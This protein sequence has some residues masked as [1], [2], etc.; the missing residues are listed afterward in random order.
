MKVLFFITGLGYGGAETETV[1]LAYELKKRGHE[2]SFITIITPYANGY[3]TDLKNNGIPVHALHVN[4]KKNLAFALPRLMKWIKQERP[5]II[6]AQMYAPNIISR[7]LKKFSS[8]NYYLINTIQNTI[9]GGTLRK[10]AYRMTSGIP[11]FVSHVSRRGYNNY[12]GAN[13]IKKETSGFIP[14]SV[15]M[16][17]FADVK[18][19]DFHADLNLA[20]GTFVFLAVARLERQKDYPTLFKAVDSL[21]KMTDKPFVA[22][23]AG[24]GTLEKELHEQVEAMGLQQYIRF[25]GLRKDVPN[26]M[27][28]ADSFIMS[29][30]WEGTS[31]SLLEAMSASLPAVVTNAGDNEFV[32]IDGVNGYVSNINEAQPFAENLK[33]MMERSSGELLEMGTKSKEMAKEKFDRSRIVDRW[34]EEYEKRTK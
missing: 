19:F 9:E 1:N 21:R 12:T 20:P 23:I 5:D 18:A 14:N 25:L 10:I 7:L 32:V 34:V 22:C 6:H 13:L 33:K 30:E 16:S 29:S 27:K 4:E 11:N 15:G 28:G 2:I 17:S 31:L 3:E 8:S 24:I 26:L